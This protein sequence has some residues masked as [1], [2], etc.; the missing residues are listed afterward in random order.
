[1]VG[2]DMFNALSKPEYGIRGF[3]KEGKSPEPVLISIIRMIKMYRQSC[4]SNPTK[5]IL[6]LDVSIK[7][8][9]QTG[10]ILPIEIN[11][12]TLSVADGLPD[13]YVCYKE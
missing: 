8:E 6:S 9:S 11:G 13:T 7:F 2:N 1:M 4:G 12:C 5:I 3:S 10:C